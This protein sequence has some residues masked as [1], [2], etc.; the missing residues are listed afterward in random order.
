MICA[1]EI[2]AHESV[3]TT[4]SRRRVVD[5]NEMVVLISLE[6]KMNEVTG[7]MN[8]CMPYVVMEPA[9]AM[10]GLRQLGGQHLQLGGAA[11]G[12][13]RALGDPLLERLIERFELLFGLFSLHGVADGA[14]Q[15]AAIAV[16]FE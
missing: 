14:G 1:V 12:H 11:R 5:Q 10:L 9:F 6:L 15:N 7:M 4:M 13:G 2:W 3:V 16:P 8:L